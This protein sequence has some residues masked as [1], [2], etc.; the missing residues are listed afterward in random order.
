MRSLFFAVIQQFIVG[1]AI[2]PIVRVTSCI[3]VMERLDNP[4]FIVFDLHQGNYRR[5]RLKSLH[6]KIA[7]VRYGKGGSDIRGHRLFRRW[8]QI[9]SVGAGI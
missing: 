5:C 3:Q 7:G 8:F 4:G 9:H 2:A 1:R 6:Q